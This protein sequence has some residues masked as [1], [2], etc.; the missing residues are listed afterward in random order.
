M[1]ICLDRSAAPPR[2]RAEG[3]ERLV[4]RV[5]V[6]VAADRRISVILLPKQHVFGLIHKYLEYAFKEVEF[7]H[8]MSL[9][10]FVSLLSGR[11]ERDYGV[12]HGVLLLLSL[13]WLLLLLRVCRHDHFQPLPE[14][15]VLPL[16]G[17]LPQLQSRNLRHKL[18]L[19]GLE[20]GARD[21]LALEDVLGL[22]E[23]VLL[24]VED[25]LEVGDL[26]GLR[27]DLVGEQGHLQKRKRGNAL[28]ADPSHVIVC[29]GWGAR[30]GGE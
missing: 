19:L 29:M 18:Q 2:Q 6:A 20:R 28:M 23:D 21:H 4:G 30:W 12:D 15:D 25:L 26:V 7:I 9:K 14:V 11:R 24:V 27:L 3:L 17:S 5:R 10:T 13:L 16:D 1:V 22:A 8:K